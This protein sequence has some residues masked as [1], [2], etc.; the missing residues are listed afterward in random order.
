MQLV[1]SFI[2]LAAAYSVRK[3]KLEDDVDDAVYAIQEASKAWKRPS[4]TQS[5]QQWQF[6]G[7]VVKEFLEV[8]DISV[9]E[10]DDTIRRIYGTSGLAELAYLSCE[11]NR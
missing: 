4:K 9:E 6:I 7:K 8:L 2:A 10:A 3:G 11:E 1:S 5:R